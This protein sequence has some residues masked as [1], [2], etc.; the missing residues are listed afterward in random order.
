MR[1]MY[2]DWVSY[3]KRKGSPRSDKKMKETW[4]GWTGTAK[5]KKIKKNMKKSCDW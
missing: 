5:A 3:Y 1:L 2:S 4:Q